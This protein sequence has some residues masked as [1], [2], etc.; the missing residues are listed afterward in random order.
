MSTFGYS[1]VIIEKVAEKEFE[2]AQ[3]RGEVVFSTIL[4]I[5]DAGTPDSDEL[6]L[7]NTKGY[8]LGKLEDYTIKLDG[9]GSIFPVFEVSEPGQP[10]WYVRCDWIDQP[11]ICSLIAF[12]SILIRHIR[13][14]AT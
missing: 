8:V 13:I 7:A 5:A 1:D 9:N 4:Y 11:L 6:H 3:L 10:L 12:P 2:V 14:I